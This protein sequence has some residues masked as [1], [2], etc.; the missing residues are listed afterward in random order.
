VEN[1]KLLETIGIAVYCCTRRK[2]HIRVRSMSSI[3][4]SRSRCD[5]TRRKNKNHYPSTNEIEYTGIVLSRFQFTASAADCF[6]IHGN[7]TCFYIYILENKKK[8]CCGSRHVRSDKRGWKTESKKLSKLETPL[9]AMFCSKS[10]GVDFI[11][12]SFAAQRKEAR[13][14]MY[15]YKD[16][17]SFQHNVFIDVVAWINLRFFLR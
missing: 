10:T 11:R 8:G 4:P 6:D 2:A 17:S 15:P 5:S 12:C 3:E 14:S 7:R 9:R 16:I 13:I 1:D